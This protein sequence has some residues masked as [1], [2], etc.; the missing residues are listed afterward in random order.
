MKQDTRTLVAMLKE[1]RE[2]LLISNKSLD[3]R[4]LIGKHTNFL[5]AKNRD[6][7]VKPKDKHIYE[8]D[9]GNSRSY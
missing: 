6:I 9:A 1:E 5:N 8:K 7:L 2:K 4:N 3:F